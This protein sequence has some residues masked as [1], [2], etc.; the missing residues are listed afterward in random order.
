MKT[1]AIGRPDIRMTEHGATINSRMGLNTWA[2]FSGTDADAMV[3]G[4]VAMLE[5]SD[6]G[7]SFRSVH[8]PSAA[9]TWT[10]VSN[11]TDGAWAIA[12]LLDEM[13]LG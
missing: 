3:A 8:D 1:Q 7:V 9:A 5:G 13:L 2:A 10:V 11:T 6:A 4:D 12:G